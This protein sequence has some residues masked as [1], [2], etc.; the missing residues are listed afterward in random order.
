MNIEQK[1]EPE[2]LFNFLRGKRKKKHAGEGKMEKKNDR[3]DVCSCV[4]LLPSLLSYTV[5]QGIWLN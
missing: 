3:V 1:N 5:Y 2:P 4:E